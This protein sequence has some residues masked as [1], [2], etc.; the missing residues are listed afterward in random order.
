MKKFFSLMLLLVGFVAQAQLAPP[1][2][3]ASASMAEVERARINSERARLEAGFSAEE[4]A[5]YKKFLVN[6]CLDGIK[7]R[8]R[9][10]MADLR[11]QEVSLDEQDRKARAAEQIRKTEEK[12]S[13]E[14]QQEA[15]DRRA[16]ALKDFDERMARDQQK[17]ADREIVKSNVKSNADS[18]ASRLTSN[19]QKASGR[20]I[21]QA[22]SAEEVRKFNERQEKAKERQAR[23]ER[24]EKARTSPPAK[25]LPQPD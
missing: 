20:S 6:N 3:P 12:S 10:A 22:E 9:E 23:H 25:S 7:P 16:S 18:A 14:K 11:R 1:A 13:A 5:C 15:A 24:D 21:K 8:R 17:N 4:A 19:Q 2:A